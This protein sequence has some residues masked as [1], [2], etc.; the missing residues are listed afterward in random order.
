MGIGPAFLRWMQQL[1]ADPMYSLGNACITCFIYN[2]SNYPNPPPNKLDDYN[3]ML[4]RQMEDLRTQ[5]YFSYFLAFYLLFV[6]DCQLSRELTSVLAEIVGFY[7]QLRNLPIRLS[8]H[9]FRNGSPMS[10]SI[11]FWQRAHALLGRNSEALS[12][13]TP[14]RCNPFFLQLQYIN[15]HGLVGIKR[16]KVSGTYI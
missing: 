7:I 5:K 12:P 11:Y 3:C 15:T 14:L 1:Y 16:G 4:L 10:T 2:C 13:T 8:S 9:V 6:H